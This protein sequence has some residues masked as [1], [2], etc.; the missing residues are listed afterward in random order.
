MSKE[1]EL[2][3]HIPFCVK[4]CSYCDFLSFPAGQELQEAYV[5]QLIREIEAQAPLGRDHLVTSVFLGG[6]TPSLLDP[7]LILNI[8]SAVR[9]SFCVSE[10]AEI[11][12]ECNPGSTLRHKFAVYKKAGINRLS[13]GLQSA[14]NTELRMLGRIHSYEEFLKC[15]QGA[16]ME[17][18]D[19]INV[20]LIN[21]IP[22]QTMKTWRK[23]LRQVTMLRPEHLSVYN[24]IV[25]EGTP[26][27]EMQQKGLLMLPDEDEQEEIDTFTRE[28]L[29][30]NGYERYEISNY[31]REGKLCRHNV[32]YWTEVPYLGFGIGAA[33][34]YD[35]TRWSNTRDINSYLGAELAAPEGLSGIR[36]ESRRLTEAD[37][38]EEFMFLGLRMVNGVSE[39]E[40]L[41]RFGRTMDNVYGRV[42]DK[43]V[44]NGL[45]IRE[46]YRYRLSER[47]MDISNTVLSDFLLDDQEGISDG[48]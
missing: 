35:G 5:R 36:A 9:H 8:M 13:I 23:T 7:S 37:K 30:K 25:E 4:K 21:C 2:Y 42:L 34:Y 26:Y 41:Q 12:I 19:N 33:S 15:Y 18:F 32:G 16:R 48:K 20:D 14:E 3:I 46:G 22:M 47:G 39:T 1:L 11:T 38:M 6:G 17:G 31:A 44:E 45:I 29:S 28:F 10:D 24:L 27:Y 40:F 43:Y